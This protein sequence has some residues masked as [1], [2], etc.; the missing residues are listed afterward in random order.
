MIHLSLISVHSRVQGEQ[1]VLAQVITTRTNLRDILR[2]TRWNLVDDLF[3]H[4]KVKV[5]P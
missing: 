1:R 3:R 5:W 4:T 2:A